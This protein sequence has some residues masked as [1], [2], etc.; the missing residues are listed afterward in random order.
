MTFQLTKIDAV[1]GHKLNV[2]ATPARRADG[3]AARP[4]DTGNQK[5]SKDVAAAAG[6][7]Y[8]AYV[9]GDQTVSVHK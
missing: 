4:V 8:I 1:D 2:R 3:P 5:H 6:T 7:Q 9:E